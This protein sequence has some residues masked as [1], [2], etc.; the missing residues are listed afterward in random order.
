MNHQNL[1]SKNEAENSS[2]RKDRSS[3]KQETDAGFTNKP[4]VP[5]YDLLRRIGGGAYG[6]VW[7]ARSTATG[8]LR[9]AKIVWRHTFDDERPFQR[10]F[11]GIQRFEHISR[12]HP[13][14]LAL[15]HIGRN[16]TSGY[17]YYVM[18]LADDALPGQ[19]VESY[20]PRTFRADIVNGRVS[21]T[22]ILEIAMILTEALGHLHDKGLVHRDVKPSN[23][24]FVNGCP[25][26]ADVGLVTDMTDNRSIVGTEGYLPPEGPGAPSADIF[27]LGKVLYEAATGMDRREFPKLPEDLRSWPDVAEIIELNEIILKACAQDAKSR[28]Q[29]CEEM[30]TDLALLGQGKSVKQKRTRQHR[31]K[32]MKKVLTLAVFAVLAAGAI[33]LWRKPPATRP[34]TTNAKAKAFYDRAVQ[35][36]QGNAP[37]RGQRAYANLAEAVKLDPRFLDA[38]YLMFETGF[39]GNALP[40]GNYRIANHLQELAPDSAEYHTVNSFNKLNE[41]MFDDAIK[42]A[43]LATEINPKLMRAHALYGWYLALLHGDAEG[44][45]QEYKNAEDIGPPDTIVQTIMAG[46]YFQKHRFDL[47]IKQLAN[48][49]QLEPNAASPHERLA[50]AYEADKQYDK[51]IDEY[52]AWKL[53]S[54]EDPTFTANWHQNMRSILHHQGSR[55]W[56]QA[57]LDGQKKFSYVNP[58]WMAQ[59]NAR[60]ENTDKVFSLLER[61]Y[62]EHNGQMINLLEDDHWDQYRSDD[63]FK[64]LLEKVGFPK[65]MPLPKK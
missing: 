30:R 51:A 55:G 6:D 5:D 26:L 37:G 59:I 23:V 13:S 41:W 18:E 12:E 58:Y 9:A 47:A 27:A 31:W 54:G 14:Q 19:T 43:K 57:Q 49:I 64:A 42:E 21:A 60:L 61:A 25:K 2:P 36:L 10:E 44:A 38:Y 11:E 7:L 15:F 56:W 20:S 63:R 52:E 3:L 28:Y 17:F 24:I 1:T 65:G 62:R 33:L 29:T 35:D 22:K 48:A 50:E 16:D 45:L 34:S 46:P 32:V 53:L 39:Y 40:G 4:L 8:V